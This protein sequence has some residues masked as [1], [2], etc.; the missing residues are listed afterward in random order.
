MPFQL[1]LILRALLTTRNSLVQSRRPTDKDLDLL[2]FLR[3]RQHRLK[4]ILGHKTTTTLPLLWRLIQQIESLEALRVCVLHLFQ[5]LLQQDVFLFY[6]AEDDGDFGLLVGVGEDGADE[7]EHRRYAGAAGDEGDVLVLVLSPGV[8][9]QWALE[10]E[11]LA[12][13][14]VVKV[15]AHGTVRV[16]LDDEL[17]VAFCA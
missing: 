14:H 12:G 8:L 9:W 6:V 17:E 13:F 5:L 16:L 3:L 4:Q 15:G 11:S 2:A 10:V 1:A 7:L